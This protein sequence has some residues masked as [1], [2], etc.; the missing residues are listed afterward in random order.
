MIGI[1]VYVYA[2]VY[3][4]VYVEACAH[5]YICIC[6]YTVQSYSRVL[7]TCGYQRGYIKETILV[8]SCDIDKLKQLGSKINLSEIGN[9]T[10]T[11]K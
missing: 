8:I 5:V 9:T 11:P 2:Y 4:Y 7:K 10:N 3:A 6:T 1:Y